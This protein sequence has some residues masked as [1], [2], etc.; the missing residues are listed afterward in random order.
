[1]PTVEPALARRNRTE[2]AN[3]VRDLLTLEVD[4]SDLLPAD[5]SS[6]GFD[7]VAG[8]LGLSQALLERYLAAARTIARMAV[9][10]PLPTPD[11]ATYRIA[12]DVQQH[13]RVPG[14]PFGTRGGTLARH[15]FPQDGEYE[16]KID[17]AGVAAVRAAHTLAL[18]IDGD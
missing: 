4:A 14:L 11:G 13:D 18:A 15:F 2:Y 8:V 3:A 6:Y 9:G 12:P 17:L 10:S 5:D 1:M 7:N 16:F